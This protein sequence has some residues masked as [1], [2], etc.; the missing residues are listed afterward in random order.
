MRADKCLH[1]VCLVRQFDNEYFKNLVNYEWECREG[2]GG[3]PQWYVKGGGPKAPAA[4]GKG[5]QEIIMLTTDVALATDPEYR[6]YVEEFA[7]D[8]A[9]FAKAFAEVW[10]KLT[11]RE[12]GTQFTKYYRFKNL[13]LLDDEGPEKDLPDMEK[14]KTTEEPANKIIN[15]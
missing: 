11:N 5:E 13:K 2:P 6:K 4:H 1:C 7:N 8:E 15:Y 14:K 3:S 9:A 12:G 10:Y